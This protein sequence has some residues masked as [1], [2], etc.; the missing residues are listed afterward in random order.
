MASSSSLS[1]SANPSSSDA[2]ALEVRYGFDPEYALDFL[3][4]SIES[5]DALYGCVGAEEGAELSHG[6]HALRRLA[7]AL[8]LGQAGQLLEAVD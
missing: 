6:G 3:H 5:C 8:G 7:I 2:Q 4:P 1:L